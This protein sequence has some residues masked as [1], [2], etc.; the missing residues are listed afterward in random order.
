MS[1]SFAYIVMV[2]I[3]GREMDGLG[4]QMHTSTR[5]LVRVLFIC[6]FFTLAR[7]SDGANKE[8]RPTRNNIHQLRDRLEIAWRNSNQR[9]PPNKISLILAGLRSADHKSKV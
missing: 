8:C 3:I 1:S 9:D 6:F 2:Q 7:K 4:Q 5:Q